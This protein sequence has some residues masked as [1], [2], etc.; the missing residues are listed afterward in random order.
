MRSN[1]FQG[2]TCRGHIDLAIH[3]RLEVLT[4]ARLAMLVQGKSEPAGDQ[5]PDD[6]ISPISLLPS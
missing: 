2:L 4:D 5:V 3:R 1:P 6:T